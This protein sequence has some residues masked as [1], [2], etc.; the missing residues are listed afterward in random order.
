MKCGNLLFC[1]HMVPL[2]SHSQEGC[3][4]RLIFFELQL[5][6]DPRDHGVQ[7]MGLNVCLSI[8][9]RL[10]RLFGLVVLLAIFFVFNCNNNFI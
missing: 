1:D 2:T 8:F 10:M 6:S 7:S 5:L 4:V 9:V 3:F